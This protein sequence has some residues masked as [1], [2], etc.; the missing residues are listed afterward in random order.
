MSSTPITPDTPTAS[1]RTEMFAGLW[2]DIYGLA[3]A[4]PAATA[5][6]ILWLHHARTRSK[7]HMADFAN[8]M[9]AHW[10]AQPEHHARALLCVAFDQRNH[11]TRLLSEDANKS[12]KQGNQRH[13]QDMVGGMAGMVADTCALMDVLE[14]YLFPQTGG[15]VD[16]HMVLGKS[17]GGHTTWQTLFADERVTAGVAIVGCADFM[18]PELMTNRARNAHI[19]SYNPE[20]PSS[21]LGSPHFPADCVRTCTKYDPRGIL[22]GTAAIPPSA[23]ATSP[24]ERARISALLAGK[25]RGKRI[26]ATFGGADTLVPYAASKRF[27]DYVCEA[28]ETW[29]RDAQFTVVRQVYEA[30]GHDFTE[31]MIAESLRFLSD[32][33][34]EAPVTAR[35]KI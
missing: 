30:A 29:A 21:I 28:T 31:D 32:A 35:H 33:M 20:T 24:Q 8:R 15:R 2:V 9:L 23:A 17:L 1:K 5:Y 19:P 14:G 22:F 3:E 16:Q 7:G 4:S 6:T 10:A 34:K 18:R 27:L 26:L 12:W 25:V 13:A 11:G